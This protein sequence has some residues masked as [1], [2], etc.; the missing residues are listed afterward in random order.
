MTANL[1]CG[2]KRARRS[3]V[4]VLHTMIISIGLALAPI[5]P[6]SGDTAPPPPAPAFAAQVEAFSRDMTIFDSDSA[7]GNNRADVP[8]SGTTTAPDGA[9]IEARV[10]QADTGIE[11]HGWQ[12][13][14]TVTGGTWSGTF[15]DAQRNTEWLRVQVRVKGSSAPAGTTA[16][17]FGVGLVFVLEDQSNR[18]QG[19][20]QSTMEIPEAE[21]ETIGNDPG[22]FQFIWAGEQGNDPKSIKYI[23]D[24][25]AHTAALAAMA[26][27]FAKAMPGLKVMGAFI[28]LGGSPIED[29][30]NDADP[31]RDFSTAKAIADT[32]HA[33][34]SKAGMIWANHTQGM[35]DDRAGVVAALYGTD[36]AGNVLPGV[37]QT[38]AFSAVTHFGVTMNHVLA[39]AFPEL[40]DGRMQ[41]ISTQIGSWG[42]E[43]DPTLITTDIDEFVGAA[44]ERPAF[45]QYHGYY[46]AGSREPNTSD[47]FRRGLHYSKDR[48]DGF[49]EVFRLQAAM[50][51]QAGGLVPVPV[52]RIDNVVWTP[53]YVEVWSDAGPLTTRQR[54]AGDTTNFPVE[55]NDDPLIEG[56]AEVLG[57]MES[58]TENITRTEIVD[59]NGN[60]ALAGRIRIYPN[61]GEFT[62]SSSLYYM[63]GNKVGVIYAPP[64]SEV[65]PW[66]EAGL[67]SHFAVMAT[68]LLPN[69]AI[70]L[71]PLSGLDALSDAN[72]IAPTGDYTFDSTDQVIAL[73]TY[74]SGNN[75]FTIAVRARWT[76][77]QRLRLIEEENSRLLQFNIEKAD[78]RIYFAAKGDGATTIFS[79]SNQGSTDLAADADGF[80]DIL[81]HFN[82]TAA[83]IEF[84]VNGE[85]YDPQG[86]FF[87]NTSFSNNVDLRTG[88]THT[89]FGLN[90]PEVVSY[91]YWQGANTGAT[92]PTATPRVE[93]VATPDGAFTA[94]DGNRYDISDDGVKR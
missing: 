68:P 12:E 17:R 14:A 11:V 31:K 20:Q 81:M 84:Y 62:S 2:S 61:S 71:Q 50:F 40:L 4:E 91:R 49:P 69:T 92:E 46:R 57:F 43:D 79:A 5:A 58:R 36:M 70:P 80:T 13:V 39:E 73:G 27:T 60:P 30:L 87:D 52:P 15:T 3:F 34:G 85:Q 33:D 47:P 28:T 89:A 78:G 7:R 94:P 93:I 16:N 59:D 65:R 64:T 18:H 63:L 42:P 44:G 86:R 9:T 1:F 77:G 75:G 55:P 29:L 82:I 23:V 32:I 48:D 10:V 76:A 54:M 72:T 24:G 25:D 56:Q 66:Y 41:Q 22:D 88:R 51:L 21:F 38:Q 8:L 74:Q 83:R 35:T 19:L 6:V 90:G 53:D 67:M 45:A 37:D 26:A